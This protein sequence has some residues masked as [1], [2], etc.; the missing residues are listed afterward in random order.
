MSSVLIMA[1]GTGGHVYPGLAVARALQ[2]KGI[3]VIW[4][5]TRK[6]LE[7]RVIP[8]AGI[9]LE[10]ISISGLKGRGLLHWLL[11]PFRILI[12]LF[13]AMQILRRRHPSMVLSMGGFVAGPGGLVA[14]LM[15]RPLVIHEQN[16]IPGFTNRILAMFARRIL[17]GFPGVFG[18]FP[19]TLHTGNPVRERIRSMPDPDTRL[20][21][22]QGPLRVLI[23]GGSQG[24]RRLNQ[25]VADVMHLWRDESAPE[26]W[27][28]C[29]ERLLEETRNRYGKRILDKGH[30]RL[31]PFIEDMEKAYEWAD[32]VICRSGAMTVSELAC[33]GMASILVPFPY[34]TDDHQTANAN[35]LVERDAAVLIPEDQLSVERLHEVLHE[36][37][38]NRDVIKQMSMH[39]RASAMPD[40]TDTV[41][42][43]C[44]EVMY[45]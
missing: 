12:A 20:Q 27:H 35:Y 10:Y 8:E 44:R 6:G 21:S 45:A 32:L 18:H 7:A 22:H 43:V 3:E 2:E 24:A 42:Q 15:G 1:G 11:A 38:Q 16:A 29:G 5:G 25:A 13:Q 30:I 4:L 39:A 41:S 31:V 33:A 40:A 37:D 17:T 9:E 19:K 36:L 23:I 14:W 34:A 28:Q 26:I